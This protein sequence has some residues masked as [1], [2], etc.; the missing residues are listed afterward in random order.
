MTGR[1]QGLLASAAFALYAVAGAAA[2]AQPAARPEGPPAGGP[3]PGKS[4]MRRSPPSAAEHAARLRDLLQLKPAQ[5]PALTAYVS[6]L[7][8]AREGMIGGAGA[9]MSGAAPQTTPER[10]AR[11]QQLMAQHQSAVTS[12]IEATRRFYDQLDPAQK[13]AFDAL[14]PMMLMM[15]GSGMMGGPGMMGG[16]GMMG[17]GDGMPMMGPP[18]PP[19]ASPA[20]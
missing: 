6:A 11:M 13:R 7:E 9:M 17:G 10:L 20:G 18:P 1:I 4:I 5:E 14:P 16:S 19:A 12:A 8:N 15:H 2:F 3:G